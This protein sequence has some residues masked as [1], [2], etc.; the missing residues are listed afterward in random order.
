MNASRLRFL[1]AVA[2]DAAG[3]RSEPKRAAF[4]IKAR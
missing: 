3:N 4:R 2:T 1:V